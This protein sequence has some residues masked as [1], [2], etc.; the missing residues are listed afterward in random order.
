[1]RLRL[2]LRVLLLVAVANVL[3]FG[4][5]LAFLAL[6]LS[7]DRRALVA[8]FAEQLAYTLEPTIRSGG[9]LEVAQLLRWPSWRRFED[10]IIL[11]E[12][13]DIGP[14]G[15]VVPRG[16]FLNPVGRGRRS[17]LFDQ[18]EVLRGI[19]AS[20]EGREPRPAAGGAPFPIADEEGR[21]WGGGWVALPPAPGPSELARR[22]APWF[23]LSTLLLTVGT[24][25]ALSRFVLVPVRH[26]AEGA[27]LVAAG[28]FSVRLE[29]PPR[30]DELAELV[31][32]FNEMTATVQRYNER[33][34]EDVRAATEQARRAE[35]AAMTQRRLAA[36]GELAAGVAHEINNPLGGLLAAVDVLEHEELDPARRR[37]YL[38]LL[39]SALERI[40]AT[41]GQ[42]LRF[43]PRSTAPGPIARAG[44]VEDA[45]ALVRHRAERLGVRLVER[46]P[47]G[48]GAGERTGEEARAA[49][50]ALPPVAGEP[51]ELAQAVLNLLVN[52]L[53]ALEARGGGGR[54]E[55]ALS[56]GE[57]AEGAFV[58]L[59]VEDDG[60][61]V[62]AALLSRVSDLFFTTKEVGK[63][64]G[65]GLSIVHSVVASHGGKVE[66]ASEPGRGFR[67]EI[68]L[69]ALRPG[70]GGGGR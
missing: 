43:T 61:G 31:R 38:E 1:V 3:V 17:V 22:L 66:L 14:E 10:A 28:D 27:R 45:L 11:S 52:S 21:V 56:A 48:A 9:E 63:G 4:A 53:D 64:T 44:P 40:R 12:P 18:Q 26:L 41:V 46:A 62:E 25:A 35:R 5:G 32:A 51:P 42:L 59:V 19:V 2:Q 8:E 30:R 68:R 15:A 37:R 47:A 16:A 55:V 20:V 69:P 33:L 29:Q 54:V 70:A 34:A 7:E 23:L 36:M 57:D 65:L 6:R 67:V 49:W 58:R 24:F 39:R 13:W 60:P 50:R